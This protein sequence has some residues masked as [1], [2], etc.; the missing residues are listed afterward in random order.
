[1]HRVLK[2]STVLVSIALMAVG[3]VLMYL[4]P[5]T[6]GPLVKGF[7]TPII[8]LEF[9]PSPAALQI[10]FDV[11]SPKALKMAFMQGNQLD[12]VFMSLYSLLVALSG[13][14]MYN[15]TKTKALWLSFLLAAMMLCGDAL[16]NIQI[17]ALITADDFSVTQP[18]LQL[19]HFFT[20]LKWGSIGAT[21]LLFSAYFFQQGR[22]QI[23]QGLVSLTT[24]G[25]TVAA[26]ILGG[27]FHELMALSV[28]AGFLCLM[29]FSFLW[30][31]IE[32]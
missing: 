12:F 19:L 7:M 6:A 13:G 24:F 18:V 10:F 21:F 5:Q 22:W 31:P 9:M 15:H 3:G 25:L 4:N 30:K 29:V 17:A 23:I 14:M 1:M 16:E 26:F 11:E 27:I 8:A 32:N 28:F 20:W 2:I